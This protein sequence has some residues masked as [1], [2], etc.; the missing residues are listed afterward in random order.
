MRLA[1]ASIRKPGA[2][3]STGFAGVLAGL[4]EVGIATLQAAALQT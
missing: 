4:R 3:L 2:L 1:A